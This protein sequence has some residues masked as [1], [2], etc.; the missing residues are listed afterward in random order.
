MKYINHKRSNIGY[1]DNAKK[2]K[3]YNNQ[4]IINGQKSFKTVPS[5]K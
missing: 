3:I 4:I 1:K 5:Y 2:G